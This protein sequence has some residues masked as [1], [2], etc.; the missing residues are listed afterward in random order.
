[1]KGRGGRRAGERGTAAV[2]FAL[3][4]PLLLMLVLGAI[5][6]GWYFFIREVATNAA[7][8]GARVGSVNAVDDAGAAA[9]ALAAANAYLTNLGLTAGTVTDSTPTVV[10]GTSTIATVRVVVTYPVG[11]L[12]GFTLPG[13]AS[14]VPASITAVA[15]MRREGT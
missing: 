13:F 11:S 5:D 2:E 1:M 12:T 9:D 14:L 10:V 6:W 8:E 4:L 7:R 15:Q 3:V